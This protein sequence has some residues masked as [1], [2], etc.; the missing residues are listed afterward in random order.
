MIAYKF[1]PMQSVSCN[2]TWGICNAMR[3]YFEDVQVISTSNRHILPQSNTDTTNVHI[4]DA[5]TIDYRTLFQRS[6]KN[7]VAPESVKTSST[8]KFLLRLQSSFP[9]LYLFGEGNL[10]YVRN[11]VRKAARVI[12]EKQITHL[13][14]SFP[15][16]ADHLIAYRLKRRYPHLCWIADFRDL[17]IDPAQDN[18]LWRQHQEKI[19]RKILAHADIVTTV[20]NG[21]AKHLSTRHHNVY[22]LHN[23]IRTF[24]SASTQPYP[25]FTISYTGSMFQDKRRADEVLKSLRILFDSGR[26]LS[27]DVRIVYAGKDSAVWKPL[28]DQFGLTDI[29]IDRGM[30][31][32]EEAHSIQAS[33]HINLLLT[34]TT[35]ELTGNLTGK[36]YDYLAA[37]RP[38]LASVNGPRDTE[39]E[40]LISTTQSGIVAYPHEVAQIADFIADQY[41]VWKE[42]P[43]YSTTFDDQ[44]LAKLQWP[45]LVKTFVEEKI[46]HIANRI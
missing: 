45:Y 42:N 15:P 8:G 44:A 37:R 1:P 20:S 34:Y 32:E 33:S 39:L 7:A 21:L 11:A 40:Q 13:F 3:N 27:N 4:T 14:S 41:R 43:L 2:R 29:F 9:T 35:D 19:N 10:Y 31:S 46:P 36:I 25:H 22:V 18:L 24:S 28:I 30:V 12:N 6:G 5:Q 23:G 17:H 16:Y 26:L 38:V